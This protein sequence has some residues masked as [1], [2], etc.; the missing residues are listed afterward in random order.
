MNLEVFSIKLILAL[1]SI[2]VGLIN[3]DVSL[4]PSTLSIIFLLCVEV[5]YDLVLLQNLSARNI[6][7]GQI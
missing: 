3:T 6:T 5:K 2:F 1:K 4:E 7:R